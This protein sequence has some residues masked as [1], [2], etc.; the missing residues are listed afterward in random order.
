MPFWSWAEGHADWASEMT[1]P[2]IVTKGVHMMAGQETRNSFP[3]DTVLKGKHRPSSFE[4][5]EFVY[6]GSHSDVGGYRPGEGARWDTAAARMRLEQAR[7]RLML[8]RHPGA[9]S[10]TPTPAEVQQ[11]A[12]DQRRQDA[13]LEAA[14][15][16][17]QRQRDAAEQAQSLAEDRLRKLEAQKATLPSRGTL[18]RN[19]K[20][21]D[22]RLYED[23]EP[24][25]G[26]KLFR[27]WF[28]P[29]CKALVDAWEDEFLHH[30]GLVDTDL[31]RFFETHVHDSLADFA[32][33][34]TLPS[35]PRVVY[36]GRDE[37][38]LFATLDFEPVP[39]SASHAA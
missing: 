13:A 17:A 22:Q 16:D 34:A 3:V 33:D 6:P 24:L 38:E 32:M 8:A 5:E 1:I 31:I 4:G 23:A 21:Y 9:S 27:R 29:H 14:V 11:A 10:M 28:R 19:W 35:D 20:Q 26:A 2:P 25:S 7:Q 12:D 18:G 37:I 39:L 36:V 15:A 30:K